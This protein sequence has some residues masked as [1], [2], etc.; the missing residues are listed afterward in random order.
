MNT[1]QSLMDLSSTEDGKR[2]IQAMVADLLG[3]H[4][5]SDE[6]WCPACR[7]G[8]IGSH[9]TYDER[10]DERIGGCGAFVECDMPIPD[11]HTSLDAILPVVR[12]MGDELWDDY[13]D[14]LEA[15]CG[16]DG[17]Q[18][19]GLNERFSIATAEAF[20]HCIAFILTHQSPPIP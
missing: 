7:C 11:F 6:W 12:N 10:H 18:I 5:S 14:H 16:T 3:L 4:L 20:R 9:V 15:A 13:I 2:H 17:W 1:L 8:V 19:M